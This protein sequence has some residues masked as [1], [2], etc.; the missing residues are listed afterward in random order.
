MEVET[1]EDLKK[2]LKDYGYSD[3]AAMEIL[4]WYTR[5]PPS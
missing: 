1:V 4:K 5:G 2:V 3:K